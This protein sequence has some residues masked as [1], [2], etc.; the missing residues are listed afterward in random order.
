LSVEQVWALILSAAFFKWLQGKVLHPSRMAFKR[1]TG[2]T[3]EELTA[4][5][6]IKP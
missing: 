5:L 2:E 4:L 6:R 3:R 1:C